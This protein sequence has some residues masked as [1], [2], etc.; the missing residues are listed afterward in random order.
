MNNWKSQTRDLLKV[1]EVDGSGVVMIC[2]LPR[3]LFHTT[4]TKSAQKPKNYPGKPEP[5]ET[6]R[7][8]LY[9]FPK[10][11]RTPACGAERFNWL[12]HRKLVDYNFDAQTVF[13]VSVHIFIKLKVFFFFWLLIR[14]RKTLFFLLFICLITYQ[15]IIQ[16]R[17]WF[18]ARCRL[19]TLSCFVLDGTGLYYVSMDSGSG[20]PIHPE[21]VIPSD[22]CLWGP[23][24]EPR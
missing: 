10:T 9:Q 15:Q 17:E 3:R 5:P 2:P 21:P 7:W 23:G 12:I 1:Q 18:G 11:C 8:F 13:L 19:L 20:G 24:V 4:G 6:K 16:Q 22:V 14:L